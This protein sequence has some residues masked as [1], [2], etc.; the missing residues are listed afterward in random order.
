[1]IIF[2]S[3]KTMVAHWL[4]VSTYPKESGYVGVS[5]YLCIYEQDD[6]YAVAQP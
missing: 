2:I 5:G 1:M 6:R 4:K 3:S